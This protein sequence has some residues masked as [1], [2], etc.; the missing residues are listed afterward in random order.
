MNTFTISPEGWLS[1]A[2]IYPSLNFNARPEGMP[3]SLLVLHSISLPPE[4]FGVE[5]VLALFQ[6][7]LEVDKDPYYE[8]LKGLRVSSHFLLDRAGLIYQCVSI[9]DRAWHAGKSSFNGITNCNDYSIGIELNG[10]DHTG[11]TKAQ[12]QNLARLTKVLQSYFPD[13][14]ATRVVGH[15]DIARPLGRK[16]DPGPHFD[17]D[18]YRKLLKEE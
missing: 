6:N 2:Q 18:Y 8:Q 10:S 7:R 3:V 11:F 14:D 4:V 15:A 16:T 5:D 13:I 17:W 12:Y 9:L 1:G